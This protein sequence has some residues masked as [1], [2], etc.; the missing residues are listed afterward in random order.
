MA[1][2]S[3]N[4]NPDD[5]DLLD[6]LGNYKCKRIVT[7][8][9]IFQTVNELAHQE[10]LQKPKYIIDCFS[11]IVA[12]LKVF[13]SFQSVS[14]LKEMY[15]SKKPTPRKIVKL[16]IASPSSEAEHTCLDHLKRYIRSLEGSG[17]NQFLAFVT[18]SDVIVCD[19]LS[20]TFLEL[21]GAEKRPIAHTCGPVLELPSTYQS[22]NELAEQFNFIIKNTITWAFTIV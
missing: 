14:C 16:L 4:L 9:N 10:I 20:V 11:S 5:E 21:V 1:A 15:D 6:V 8:D 7:T 19:G 3:N 22:Y 17:V 12:A 13:S 18:G 2:L